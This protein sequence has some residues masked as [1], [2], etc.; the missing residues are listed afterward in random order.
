MQHLLDYNQTSQHKDE[1]TGHPV[2]G[3]TTEHLTHQ[4][5]V[6]GVLPGTHGVS[7]QRVNFITNI[8]WI[9]SFQTDWPC[10]ITPACLWMQNIHLMSGPVHRED[11]HTRR[12]G[13]HGD[14]YMELMERTEGPKKNQGGEKEREMS[15][16][17]HPHCEAEQDDGT[18]QNC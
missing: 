18:L 13:P 17:W 14:C 12:L 6:L 1:C 2:L 15:F 16:K 3:D 8:D 10:P 11:W 7:P 9:T 4:P 5:P